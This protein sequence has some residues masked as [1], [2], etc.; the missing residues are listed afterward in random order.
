MDAERSAGRPLQT[1]AASP[2]RLCR[3]ATGAL[4]RSA[5]T[6]RLA[7]TVASCARRRRTCSR[8]TNH[9][10]VSQLRNAMV[11]VQVQLPLPL[12]GAPHRQQQETRAD[13]ALLRGCTERGQA[14][15]R[16]VIACRAAYLQRLLAPSL[17]RARRPLPAR[18]G[19]HP[20]MPHFTRPHAHIH[21]PKAIRHGACASYSP[22]LLSLVSRPHGASL[23]ISTKH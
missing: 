21:T 3:G 16:Y 9:R 8:R 1:T 23:D 2:R 7:A 19:P 11:Q 5:A 17:A 18:P 12:P 13:S 10:G 4:L 14:G 20:Q 15:V 22:L 6:R